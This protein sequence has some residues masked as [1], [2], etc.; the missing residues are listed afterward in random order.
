MTRLPRRSTRARLALGALAAV[1]LAA[2]L[3]LASPAA[4]ESPPPSPDP[5]LAPLESDLPL[6][7]I[8]PRPNSGRAPDSPNDPG[9]WQQYLVLGLIVGAMA[10]IVALVVR[11]SRRARVR[12]S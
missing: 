8:I 1:V 7:D 9:G 4:A 2:S 10:L 6:G 3:A 11:E 12:R 5:T